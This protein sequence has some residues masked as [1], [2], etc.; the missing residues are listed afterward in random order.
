MAGSVGTSYRGDIALDD[1]SMAAGPCKVSSSM[2][3]IGEDKSMK[4]RLIIKKC[5]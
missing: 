2:Y 5:D 1:I 3:W 4:S